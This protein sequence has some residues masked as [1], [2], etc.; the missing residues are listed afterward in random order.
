[1]RPNMCN[2][3]SPLANDMLGKLTCIMESKY[4]N[5]FITIKFDY[6]LLPLLSSRYR[7]LGNGN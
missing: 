7:V 1:M 3:W 4:N 2:I 6:H 5:I